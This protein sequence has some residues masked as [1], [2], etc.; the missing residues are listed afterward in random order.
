MKI[1]IV[2][3]YFWPEDFKVN[4]IAKYLKKRGH[5]VEVLTGIP[6][7]PGGHFYRDYGVF[8][9]T[10][11][12]YEGIS[13]RR[14]PIVPRGGGKND[15]R[16][17]PN[18]LSFVLS[19][20]SA[21][22]CMTGNE[23]D[24]V[25]VFN[26]SPITQAYAAMLL[27]KLIKIPICMYIY[28]LWPDTLFSH[29]LN[30]NIFRKPAVAECSRIYRSFD[31]LLITSHG[32]EKRL[33]DYGCLVEKIEYIPQ[34]AEKIYKPMEPTYRIRKKFGIRKSDF[35][36]MF[37]GNMG[38][39]QDLETVVEATSFTLKNSTIKYIFVGDGTEKQRC[40]QLCKRTN[41]DNCY[42]LE[43]QA[44][45]SMPE[46]IADADVMLVTLRDKDNYSLTLPSRVQS[47]M[48]CKKPILVCAGGEVAKVVEEAGAGLTC[49]AGRSRDLADIIMRM[50]DM[51][52]K[53]RSK[54]GEN[55][56]SYVHKTFDED[57]LLSAVAQSL[58][59]L[60]ERK[61]VKE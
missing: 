33:I 42:F 28:D 38:F 13:I 52:G 50:A 20:C 47:F 26:V 29:G 39:A 49:G 35:V 55:G 14:V 1:L 40:I 44:A 16:L 3:Q 46:V 5:N 57:K 23:Y 25:F 15:L 12:E 2:T 36:V 61:Q 7:Y 51:S 34:W 59:G 45:E 27:K 54:Y 17:V 6:N 24:V 30:R 41:P 22:M 56:F 4:D 9:K 11:E 10:K 48:A 37:A 53:D 8:K 21:I 18:Y 58:E 43:R 19:S 32:F 60:P 31:R